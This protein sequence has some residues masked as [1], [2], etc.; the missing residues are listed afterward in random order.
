MTLFQIFMYLKGLGN[1]SSPVL[2]KKAPT[3]PLWEKKGDIPKREYLLEGVKNDNELSSQ[4]AHRAKQT[5]LI[6]SIA[7]FSVPYDIV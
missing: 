4:G 7:Y 6:I 3:L 2:K 1:L 5:L